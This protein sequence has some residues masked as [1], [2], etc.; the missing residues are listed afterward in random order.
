MRACNAS[1]AADESNHLSAFYR[2]TDMHE[3]STHMEVSGNYAA[4]MVDV[5]DIARREEVGYQRNDASISRPNRI[6][7]SAAEINAEVARGQL[8]VEDSA[9]SEFARNYRRAWLDERCCPHRRAIVRM[10]ADFSR[11]RVLTINSCLCCSVEWPGE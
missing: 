1:R 2:F 4:A 11:F 7:D 3:R 10:C 6:T 5:K 9:G 8:T